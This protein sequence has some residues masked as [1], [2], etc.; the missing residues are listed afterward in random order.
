MRGVFLT[1]GLLSL[2]SCGVFRD[3]RE[4]LQQ[5]RKERESAGEQFD[6]V[7]ETLGRAEQV[8]A[9]AGEVH[10]QAKAAADKDGDG[11][12]SGDEWITYMLMAGIAGKQMLDKRKMSAAE[13]EIH[14]RIDHEREKRKDA[15]LAALRA[16]A[17]KPAA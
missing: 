4:S 16:A 13:E 1:I 8:L 14:A 9:K 7:K 2:T 3:M 12:L 11:I 10:D 5:A 17:G 6:V 15:E